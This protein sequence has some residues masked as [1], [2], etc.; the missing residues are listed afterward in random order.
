M[1]RLRAPIAA[2]VFSGF[3]AVSWLVGWAFSR[4]R[5]GGGIDPACPSLPVCAI[6][7]ALLWVALFAGTCAFFRLLDRGG[8]S[9]GGRLAAHPFAIPLVAIALCW[10]PYWLVFFPGS[11]PWDGVRSM[12][13]FITDAPLENHHPV[14]M[15]ALYAGLMTLGR[16]L[17][18]DNL[19][20]ALIVG[21]QYAVC[22]VAFAL[23]IRET[24]R[25]NA[26]RWMTWAALAFFCLCPMWGVFAQAAFKDTLFNGIFCLYVV[27]LA[28]V[29]CPNPICPASSANSAN[30]VA[31][32]HSGRPVDL[33]NVAGP[34]RANST[35][36]T[37]S[38]SPDRL[39][40]PAG[41]Q[42]VVSAGA[43]N[44]HTGNSVS[45][46]VRPG[47]DTQT[48]SVRAWVCFLAASL[49]LCFV[50]NNGVYLALPTT[51]VLSAWLFV[52]HRAAFAA[53]H[54]GTR[55]AEIDPSSAESLRTHTLCAT[56]S[57]AADA[58]AIW[59][60]TARPAAA[61]PADRRPAARPA[62]PCCPATSRLPARR[63]LR[64]AAP[65][66]ATLIIVAVA[67]FG[68][69]RML[70][71]AAGIDMREDKEMLSVPLQQTARYLVEA[72]DDVT[73]DERAAIDAVVPIDSLAELYNPDLSDP[74][75]EGMRNAKGNMTDGE[76]SAYFAAW[77][78]MGLRHPGIYVR[79]TVANTYAYFYPFV[80]IGQDMARPVF[81]LYQQGLPINK[82][83]DVS[84]VGPEALRAAAFDTFT[85]WLDAPVLSVIFSPA[86]YILAFLLVAVYAI[87]RR[88]T[89]ALVVA[90]PF[91]MLLL[92]M[93]AGPLNGHL[94]Y[95]LPIAAALPVLF[96]LTGCSCVDSAARPDCAATESTLRKTA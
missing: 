7:I 95:A 58:R 39:T 30:L 24:V 78:Q 91:A 75:K 66:T 81:P 25:L 55:C 36:P 26:P 34:T 72:P 59:P 70:F 88:R 20:L 90:V 8:A 76:R 84:Y 53:C 67:W 71:P 48:P 28:R 50:R 60:A 56:S 45:S 16:T 9:V 86:P 87:S 40:H 77:A 51:L 57:R 14:L 94:R 33:A 1:R 62:S 69:S 6:A 13:Q 15:N 12:N 22:A 3:V 49:L 10:L 11:L 89:R 21:F 41:A 54:S 47:W 73:D 32:A 31:P 29:V 64:V 37:N 68:A 44:S 17:R 93:L 23:A 42:A 52:R 4:G 18:S 96:A 82:T 63:A 19:G 92:T 74:V 80:I 38:T 27:A 46:Q 83:F 43:P 61:R 2:I 5:V 35:S 79:A 65:A 85:Q